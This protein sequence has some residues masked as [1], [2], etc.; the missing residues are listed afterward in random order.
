MIGWLRSPS[1]EALLILKIALPRPALPLHLA[2]RPHGEP[3]PAAAAGELRAHARPGR[4]RPACVGR[5][6]ASR[7]GASSSSRARRSSRATSACSTPRPVTVGRGAQNDLALDSD[8]FA[9]ARHARFEPR[10]RRRLGRGHRLD[11]R[12]VRERRADR[13]AAAAGARRRRPRRRDRPEVR[14]VR[15]G[16]QRR[17]DRPGPQAPRR[18]EDS[19]VVRAA[20]LRGRGRDGRRAGRRDRVAAR[21]RRCCARAAATGGEERV[22]ALIQEANRRVYERAAEDETRSGMG[23]TI[24]AALVED[25]ARRDRP[26]R[27]LARLPHPR[28]RAR[29]ADRG[30]LARRGARP[31]RQ[32]LARGGGDPPAALGDHARARH[33]PGRRRRHVLASR[34]GRATSS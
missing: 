27:R 34:R 20:A 16:R 10:A 25:D 1:S 26:R 5:A 24:T 29:A 8:D 13:R 12:H 9:S 6:P 19:Y 30:P 21:R 31:Q 15:L 7:P 11:E 28:R 17:R 33:R 4:R 3:R 2:D 22:V 23:T 14:A 32:A 18:N